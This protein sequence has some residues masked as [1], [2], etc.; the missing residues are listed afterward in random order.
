RGRTGKIVGNA[1]RADA[2]KAQL[3]VRARVVYSMTPDHGSA[4]VRTVLEDP[5]L[6]A[7]W[8]AELDDMRSSILSLR[9][10]LAASF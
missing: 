4:I 10:G 6:A 7:D 9:Q 2:A 5:A 3:T 1:D 8:S